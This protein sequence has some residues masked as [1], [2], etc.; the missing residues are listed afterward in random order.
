MSGIKT[1][2]AEKYLNIT[3]TN[4]IAQIGKFPDKKEAHEINVL[5]QYSSP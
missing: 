2:S 1:F 3:E 5:M 4:R